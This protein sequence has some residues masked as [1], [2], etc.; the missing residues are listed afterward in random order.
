MQILINQKQYQ[1]T[2]VLT[3]AICASSRVRRLP[4]RATK[5]PAAV[6]K[7]RAM[8]AK[9]PPCVCVCVC[10]ATGGRGEAR[11]KA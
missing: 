7:P 1:M 11:I 2:T 8:K 3:H 5:M 6:A 10:V 4:R 9:V